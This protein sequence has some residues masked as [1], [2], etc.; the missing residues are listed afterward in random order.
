MQFANTTQAIAFYAIAV[1]FKG[2]LKSP[3][4]I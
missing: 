3:T 1:A 4:K 2:Y